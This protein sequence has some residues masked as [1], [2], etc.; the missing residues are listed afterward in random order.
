MKL[1]PTLARA[2]RATFRSFDPYEALDPVECVDEF[3]RVLARE[4]ETESRN[5]EPTNETR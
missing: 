3:L 1:D 4:I 2:V 5:A